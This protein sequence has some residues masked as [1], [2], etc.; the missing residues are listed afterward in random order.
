MEAHDKSF[1]FM[2]TQCYYDIPFF[3][4]AYVWDKDNWQE[5]M[6]NLTSRSQNHFL[7]SIILKVK[8]TSAG[9]IERRFVI[10]GQQRLTTLS[11]LLR[12]C[13]DH[14]IDNNADYGYDESA[15][16]NLEVKADQL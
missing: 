16:K 14:L 8:P 3:Q 9:D 4:R 6:E 5:L 15:V 7:G 12:A 1:S 2:G 13:M 11:I 10:D